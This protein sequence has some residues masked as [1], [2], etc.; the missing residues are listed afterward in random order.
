MSGLRGAFEFGFLLLGWFSLPPH[1]RQ[2]YPEAGEET[3]EELEIAGRRTHPSPSSSTHVKRNECRKAEV[4]N[5]HCT[6]VLATN[7]VIDDAATHH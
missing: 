6:E 2:C 4:E 3:P 7:Q 1:K 5:P